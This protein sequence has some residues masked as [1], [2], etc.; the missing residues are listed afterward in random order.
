M[1]ELSK[2]SSHPNIDFP[3]VADLE[4]GHTHI[5]HNNTGAIHPV[6]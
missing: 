6:D 5:T 2:D 1:H 3:D 4:T